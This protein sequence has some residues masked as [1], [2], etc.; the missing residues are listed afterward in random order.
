VEALILS[1]QELK[2][3]LEHTMSFET[4]QSGDFTSYRHMISDQGTLDTIDQ[5]RRFVFCYVN[6]QSTRFPVTFL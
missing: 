4:K 6:F 2:H 5:S 3:A 1:F